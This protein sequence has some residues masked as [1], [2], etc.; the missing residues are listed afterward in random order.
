M[1]TGGERS[2]ELFTCSICTEA[3][4]DNQH[5][6]KFLACYHTFCSHCLNQWHRQ[7]GQ[8]N[9]SHIRCPNCN[10][11]TD[12][13]ES[14][15]G[16]LQ[17]NFYI[18]N[19]KEISKEAGENKSDKHMKGCHKHGIQEA[20]DFHRH[21]LENQLLRS[22]ATKADIQI[23]IQETEIEMQAIKIEKDSATHNLVAFIQ[24][25]KRQ[26]EQCE[27]EASDAI[28]QHHA[29][30]HEKLLGKQRQLRQAKGLLENHISQSQQRTKTDDI[31]DII[32]YTTMLE[33]AT[34][35]TR[36]ETI[37]QRRNISKSTLIT[38]TNLHDRLNGIGMTCFQSL[39]PTSVEFMKDKFTAGFKSVIRVKLLDNAANKVPIACP[40]LNVQITDPHQEELPVTLNTAHSECTVTF[41]PQVSGKHKISFMC[42]GQKL[43]SEQTNI[44]VESN[45]PVMK[46]GK[47]GDGNGTFKYPSAI[48][49][50]TW[51]PS[52]YKDRLIYVWR[53][54]C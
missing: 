50:D 42:L 10:Q 18:E 32:S 38:G 26:L 16:G 40:F 34:N 29:T 44:M 37:Q 53:F 15:V 25:A 52:Q 36:L 11:L 12:V 27:Q 6:A 1:A 7:K 48:T 19:M 8:A 54:T 9:S 51:A 31:S 5:K 35:I 17:T 47:E 13:P 39:L 24:S 4:D 28:S 46:F 20:T 21:T 22:H 41:T 30:Q 2:A 23:A 33:K 43:E 14:G 3:Y 45:N 49:M